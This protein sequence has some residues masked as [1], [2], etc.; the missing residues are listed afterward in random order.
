M[1]EKKVLITGAAGLVGGILRQTWGDRY[2]LRL[3]DIQPV[4][5]LAAH[6]EFVA[7]DI[8]QY[9]EFLAACEGV[10]TVVHLAADRSPNAEFYETLLDLN[11]I[12]CYNGFEAARAAG[13]DRIVF[14]SS[15][16]AILGYRYKERTFTDSP[17]FPLKTYGPR[18]SRGCSRPLTTTL[19]SP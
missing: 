6:E 8:A 2:S 17:I 3:A 5:N 15:V 16:N 19:L 18:S 10:D 12:G 9:D 14:A 4:E 13:C 11:I 7:M 1:A